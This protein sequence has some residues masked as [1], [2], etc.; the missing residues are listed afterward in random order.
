MND[1][2]IT[3]SILTN[4]NAR[5]IADEEP[6]SL[7]TDGFLLSMR[8]LDLDTWNRFLMKARISGTVSSDSLA[9]RMSSELAFLIIS[10]SFMFS[11]SVKAFINDIK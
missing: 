5:N 1:R 6:T 4:Q 11:N 10:S 9:S 2:V 8:K 7:R 3:Q